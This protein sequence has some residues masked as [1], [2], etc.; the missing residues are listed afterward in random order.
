MA[1]AL[2]YLTAA[3]RAVLDG[4]GALPDALN[5]HGRHVIVIGG[6]DTG[7]D[8]VGAALRQGCRSVHQLEIMPRPPLARTPQNPWPEYPRVLKVDY[9]QQEAIARFGSDPRQ[10]LTQTREILRDGHG[11]CA[12]LTEGVRWV[13]GAD[14]RL[15]PQVQPGTSKRWPADL[16]LI[17]MGFTGP[18]ETLVQAYG[19]TQD[20][21]GSVLAEGFMTVRR[22]VFAAGD[23]RIGQSLVVRAIDEGQRA[24]KA[25]HA[26]LTAL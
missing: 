11:V 3:T 12:V 10:F 4:P 9:A 2:D 1:F 14:G 18:E 7:T 22:G 23:M 19:L 26:Y 5:A 16:V 17:A 20:A 6:G 25:C 24:A 13:R 15:C 8:C 21:L